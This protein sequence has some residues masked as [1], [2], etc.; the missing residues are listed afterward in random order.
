MGQQ[1]VKI[2][3]AKVVVQSGKPGEILTSDKNG[4][5]VACGENAL[6]ITQL[7]PQGKK[8]MA[9]SD[10]LNGRSDWV[11]PGTLLGENNE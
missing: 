3:Q 9:I 4:V 5:V 7:Q 8:P 10:F 1:T 2:Y 6:S 11:S